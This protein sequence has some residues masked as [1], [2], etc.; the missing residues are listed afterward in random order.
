MPSEPRVELALSAL[1]DS[2]EAFR[3]AL[4]RA[5]DEV[6]AAL[7]RRRQ[8]AGAPGGTRALGAL[9]LRC[10]DPDR[11]AGLV[12]E[13]PILD[14]EAARLMEAAHDAL[15]GMD[16][17]DD[18]IFVE[19]VPEGGSLRDAVADGLARLGRAFGAA[20]VAELAREGRLGQGTREEQLQ[21][22]PPAAWNRAERDMAPPL[23]VQTP[24][25]AITA[26]ALAEFVDGSQKVVLVVEGAAPAAPLV[27][28][29]TPGV[30]V[31]QTEDPSELESAAAFDGPAVC[32]LFPEG[33]GVASFVHDPSAAEGGESARLT[34][35]S[36][37]AAADLHRVGTITVRQ[38]AEE[39]TQ[40]AFLASLGAAA[41][42][43]PSPNGA[44]V[45]GTEAGEDVQP[46]D[47]LAAW[48]LRQANLR[49]LD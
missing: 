9:G 26:G 13:E 6:R 1:Q 45:A 22:F 30:Y 14:P 35:S 40:L 49:D 18:D 4:A 23:I 7:E 43:T 8:P 47:R 38:Q 34:I 25:S 15:A 17:A 37:P 27:R 28:L 46:A 31:L 29:I 10:M 36:L 48:L 24:G 19:T 12:A 16:A 2:L 21:T 11:F 5:V 41:P 32:A 33:S 39:L 44:R 3:S 20:R 42:A